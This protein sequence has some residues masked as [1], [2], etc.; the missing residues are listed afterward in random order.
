MH[1]Y[2]EYNIR[3]IKLEKLAACTTP[4]TLGTP[5]VGP[6]KK[7][8]TG[9]GQR[10]HRARGNRETRQRKKRKK[11]QTGKRGNG[12]AHKLQIWPLTKKIV[13]YISF[14]IFISVLCD[15]T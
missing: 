15:S 1:M 13:F 5:P 2:V 11:K 3:E 6:L 8:E 12:E 9:K 10:K 14:S 7:Q 4:E